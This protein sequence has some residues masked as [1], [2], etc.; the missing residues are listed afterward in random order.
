MLKKGIAGDNADGV[1]SLTNSL[2]SSGSSGAQNAAG[3]VEGPSDKDAEG[4]PAVQEALADLL[5]V[6]AREPG[7]VG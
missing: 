3:A 2:S 1:F 7:G 4:D 5:Q 6:C